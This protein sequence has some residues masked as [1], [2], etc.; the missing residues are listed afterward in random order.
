MND[1]TIVFRSLK[2]R[3]FTTVVTVVTVAIAV[4]LL[5]TLLTLKRAGGEAFL[6]GSGNAHL[7]VSADA[8]PIVSVLNAF[9]YA[10]APARPL[11]EPKLLEIQSSFPWKWTV[12]MQQGD[13]YRGFPTLATTTGFFSDFEPVPGEPWEFQEGRAFA[14]N[15]E[16]VVGHEVADQTG[17]RIGSTLNFTHGAGDEHG[18]VHTEYAFTVVG[19]LGPTGSAHDRA[20]FCSLES[21]WILHA[22]DRK[23]RERAE[24]GLAHEHGPPLTAADLIEADRKVTGLLIRLPTR[25]GSDVS[26]AMQPE[27]DRLRRDPTITVANPAFEIQKLLAIVSRV[28]VLF[29][30]MAVVILVG[31]AISILVALYNSMYERRRQIAIFRVL[32][33]SRGR[34]FGLVMTESALIGVLGAAS[35]AILSGV[36]GAVAGAYLRAQVGLVLGLGMDPQQTVI[37]I[38]GAVCLASLAGILPALL[39]YRT[40]VGETLRPSA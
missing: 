35:G 11:T 32:G 16:V 36:G 12:P 5:L 30:A 22:Q 1:F 23:E 17:L 15:F 9:F 37:V 24:A 27:F 40:P 28:D 6:R 2:A 29:V 31:S 4:A 33:C 21:S 38:A 7:L 18:H 20:I 14:A 13:S 25:P 10:G 34:I 39:A 19:I 26:T 8:S 3:L